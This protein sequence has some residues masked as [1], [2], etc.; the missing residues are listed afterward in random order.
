MN[1]NQLIDNSNWRMLFSVASMGKFKNKKDI[2]KIKKIEKLIKL[3][4]YALE[5]NFEEILQKQHRQTLAV[6]AKMIS[7]DDSNKHLNLD[8]LELLKQFIDKYKIT[9]IKT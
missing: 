4:D 7:E 2:N 5:G 1:K 3:S 6:M 9:N 8:Y